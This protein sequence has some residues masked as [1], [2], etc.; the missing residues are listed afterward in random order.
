MVFVN[1]FKKNKNLS[2]VQEILILGMAIECSN[3]SIGYMPTT[4]GILPGNITNEKN[5][6]SLNKPTSVGILPDNITIRIK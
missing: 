4:V 3:L 6:E 5:Q 1:L 2:N